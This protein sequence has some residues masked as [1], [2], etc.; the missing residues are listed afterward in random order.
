MWETFFSVP[1]P[2]PHTTSTSLAWVVCVLTML[3]WVG[4]YQWDTCA[5]LLAAWARIL[6]G[7]GSERKSGWWQAPWKC[8]THIRQLAGYYCTL[9]QHCFVKPYSTLSTRIFHRRYLCG[10]RLFLRFLI[11]SYMARVRGAGA[12]F[13]APQPFPE[14]GSISVFRLV[15]SWSLFLVMELFLSVHSRVC[16]RYYLVFIYFFS[17]IISL[18]VFFFF[19]EDADCL[20]ACLVYY[21]PSEESGMQSLP[22]LHSVTQLFF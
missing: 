8:I 11:L 19:F 17:E 3:G 14:L 7:P 1:V 15:H 18:F 10:K 2:S 13:G 5:V 21:T 16:H 12:A 9:K 20:I 6:G 4:Y 22:W